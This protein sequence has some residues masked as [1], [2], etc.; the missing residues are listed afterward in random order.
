MGER[1]RRLEKLLPGIANRILQQLAMLLPGA[2]GLRVALHRLRGVRI[3]K[4]VWIGHES[5]IETA[6][7]SLVSIGDR[8]II[9]IRC[10]ILAHF[11]DPGPVTIKND[12]YIGPCVLILPGVTI[13]EGA[14]VMAGSVVS[15]SVAPMTMVQ[16]NPASPVAK[17]GIPLGLSTPY[18]DFLSNLKPLR[19]ASN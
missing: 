10:T 18:K 16:G 6:W 3:G 11:H 2:M 19:A 9:G 15:C 5:L 17:C 7:P 12:A 8:V 4:D 13:G 14:V 1:K